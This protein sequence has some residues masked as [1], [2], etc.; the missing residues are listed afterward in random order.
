MEENPRAG[1]QEDESDNEI[2]YDEDGNPIAPKKSK[3][4]IEIFSFIFNHFGS[5]FVFLFQIIDPLPPIDHSTIE[6]APFEKNFYIVHE[7]I[8]ALTKD[9]VKSLR[10]T[11]GIKV[12]GPDPPRPVSSFAHFGFDDSLM[13]VIRKSEYTQPTPI[14]AQAI[15]AG[16]SGRDVLGWFH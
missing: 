12:T 16:L 1:L 13:K 4:M 7:E 8:A 11:L 5:N 10:E 9:Q 15:P 14:Q 3:V 6:Y 2:E